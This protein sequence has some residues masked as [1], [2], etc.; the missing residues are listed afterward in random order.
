MIQECGLVGGLRG[1]P[2]VSTLFDIVARRALDTGAGSFM[3]VA[4]LIVDGGAWVSY[5]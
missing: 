3:T 2:R 1:G 5:L 4:V